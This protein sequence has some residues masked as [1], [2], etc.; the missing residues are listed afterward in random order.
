MHHLI[1][2]LGYQDG[3]PMVSELVYMVIH[4]TE[5]MVSHDL[6]LSSCHDLTKLFNYVV[7]QP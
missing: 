4:L 7:S 3:F 2:A 6:R 1:V 5:P